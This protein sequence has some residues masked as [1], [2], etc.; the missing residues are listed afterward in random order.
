MTD[1][2]TRQFDRAVREYQRAHPETTLP[3]AREAVAARAAARPPGGRP[4]RIPGAPLPRPGETL[5]GYTKRVAAAAGVHRHRAMELLGLA[6]GSSAT[7]RLAELTRDPLPGDVVQALVAATGMTPAQARGLVPT[8]PAPAAGAATGLERLAR[9]VLDEK[10]IQRGGKGKT[11]TDARTMARLLAEA[12][13]RRPLL[14]DTDP[15]GNL[16]GWAEPAFRPVLVDLP[17]PAEGTT[18]P[19]D[20]GLVD[21]VLK[22]LGIGP[23]T[24]QDE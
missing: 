12:G 7:E 8:G 11:R 14:I 24:A 21:E 2:R 23:T 17:W 10:L 18:P 3:E 15:P 16:G 1:R 4:A 9:Q 20:P 6:P 22:E 13:A 5:D 19:A